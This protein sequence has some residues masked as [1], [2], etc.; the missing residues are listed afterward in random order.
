MKMTK[1]NILELAQHLERRIDE[2][3]YGGV[4]FADFLAQHIC[5]F[6]AERAQREAEHF[7]NLETWG[8]K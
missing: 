2:A 1:T 7:R 4:L 6:L 3:G 5:G 8:F